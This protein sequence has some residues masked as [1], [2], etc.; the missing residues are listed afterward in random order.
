MKPEIRAKKK[1]YFLHRPSPKAS[2]LSFIFQHGIIN[3]HVTSNASRKAK[4][5][6]QLSALD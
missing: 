6:I 5:L 1:T 4:C 3:T 2:S